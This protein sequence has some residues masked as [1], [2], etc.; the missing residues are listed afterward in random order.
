KAQ[1][2]KAHA[3][4]KHAEA[5]VEQARAQLKQ[6]EAMLRQAQERLAQLEGRGSAGVRKSEEK[7]ILMIRDADGKTRTI[8]LA[9]GSDV[10][11]KIE[12]LPGDVKKRIELGIKSVP[13]TPGFPVTPE[14]GLRHVIP[15]P[16]GAGPGDARLHELE[17]KIEAL[18]KEVESLRRE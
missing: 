16:P 1:T 3:E 5:V 2:E 10:L 7:I 11:R 12:G 13:G 17:K 18:M 14:A 8:E 6:A 4:L 15:L 9:P